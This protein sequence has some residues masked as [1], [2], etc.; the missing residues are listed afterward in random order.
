[1]VNNLSGSCRRYMGL[2][3]GPF[4]G[5]KPIHLKIIFKINNKILHIFFYKKKWAALGKMVLWVTWALQFAWV[6]PP[7]PRDV[8][9]VFAPTFQ[10]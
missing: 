4:Y 6:D 8:C 7:V 5:L 9:V 3:F 2:L 10:P 1:M